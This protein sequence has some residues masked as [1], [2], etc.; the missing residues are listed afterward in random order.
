MLPLLYYSPDG[1]VKGIC[2]DA[3]G[4]IMLGVYE[5]HGFGDGMFDVIEGFICRIRPKEGLI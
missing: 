4:I 2:C 1:S 5:E 3:D